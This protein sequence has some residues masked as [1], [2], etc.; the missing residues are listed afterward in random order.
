MQ[1][2]IK[3]LLKDRRWLFWI[4]MTLLVV[5]SFLREFELIGVRGMNMSVYALS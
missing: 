5:V 1:H 4:F 3:R 2:K